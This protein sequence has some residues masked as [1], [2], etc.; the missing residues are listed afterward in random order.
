[1]IGER[2]IEKRALPF[3]CLR[4]AAARF[5]IVLKRNV[6]HFRPEFICGLQAAGLTLI[7]LIQRLSENKLSARRVVADV[8]HLSERSSVYV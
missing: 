6:H 1:V 4:R 3:K 5:R 2:L 8:E 7:R